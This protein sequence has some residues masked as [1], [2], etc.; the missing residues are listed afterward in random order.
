MSRFSM[1]WSSISLNAITV[2]PNHVSEGI[3]CQVFSS[4]DYTAA[5]FCTLYALRKSGSFESSSFTY[6]IVS[7]DSNLL[8]WKTYDIQTTHKIAINPQLRESWP[9]RKLLQALPHLIICQDIEE[10]VL[11]GVLSQYGNQLSRKA[12]LRCAW[13]TLHEQHDRCSLDQWC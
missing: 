2:Q 10:S 7:T 5:V 6:W 1:V 12:T 13:C 8:P 9:V 11:H 4:Y 3:L